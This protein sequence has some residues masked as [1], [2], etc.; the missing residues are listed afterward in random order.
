MQLLNNKSKNIIHNKRKQIF[1]LSRS[2]GLSNEDL[3]EY[4]PQWS[5]LTSL[6]GDIP[7]QE[8]NKVIEALRKINA[9]N[10]MNSAQFGKI[11]AL[12]NKLQWNE[13]RLNGFIKHTVKVQSINNLNFTDASKII[14]GLEKLS[15]SN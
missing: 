7:V 11:K 9:K 15:A 13:A 14:I 1:A 10:K 4:L 6:K 12:Q 2:A 3:H 8:A 5:N